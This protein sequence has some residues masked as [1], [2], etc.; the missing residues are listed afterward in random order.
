MSSLVARM[1]AAAVSQ[2]V[3]HS[4]G[5]RLASCE[6]GFECRGERDEMLLRVPWLEGTVVL[7]PGEVERGRRHPLTFDVR[8]VEQVAER[9]KR[10]RLVIRENDI[11]PH[12]KTER[13]CAWQQLVLRVR[14][15]HERRLAHDLPLRLVCPGIEKPR[16]E[17]EPPDRAREA[18]G[19]GEG[20]LL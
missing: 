1:A 10:R 17:H 11:A 19:D 8:R 15:G 18:I 14:P 12:P 6:D 9:R 16:E 4:F 13:P 2:S 3:Q 20:V 5:T 7:V